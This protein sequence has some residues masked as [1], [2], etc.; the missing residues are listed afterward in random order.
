[1]LDWSK[2]WNDEIF[3]LNA[4][5]DVLVAGKMARTQE[6]TVEQKDSVPM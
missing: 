2:K 4:C 6:K 1:M 3:A 5:V